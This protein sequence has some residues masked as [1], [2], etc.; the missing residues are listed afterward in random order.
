MKTVLIILS[1][2]M[3]VLIISALDCYC[4]IDTV[5]YTL[6]DFG[7]EGKL[8]CLSDL[9]GWS[10]GKDERR[11]LER[12]EE[13]NVQ[14]IVIAGDL[15]SRHAGE[16]Q[17]SRMLDFVS[18]L[19]EMAEVYYA[20]GNHESDYIAVNGTDY[21]NKIAACGAVVLADEWTDIELNGS[22]LRIGAARGRYLNGTEKDEKTLQMLQNIGK[23]GI[24][25]IAVVHQPENI[26]YQNYADWTPD[27][28][29]CGHTHGGVWRIPGI[30]GVVAPSQ[31]FFPQYDRGQFDLDGTPMIVS[32]GLSGYLFIPR[33]FNH[34]EICIIELYGGE[35]D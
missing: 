6:P 32:A 7:A 33:V 27:L 23:D 5:R 1:V 8:L 22:A 29:L 30:G 4:H 26:L 28:Y 24:P 15:I 21:L 19:C 13:Q 11:L 9:H 35:N 31:G 18:A 14:H 16:K 12:I 17:V 34:P 3:L 25:S 10:Y 20:L 2:A